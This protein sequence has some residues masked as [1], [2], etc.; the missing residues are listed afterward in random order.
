MVRQRQ[1][2]SLSARISSRSSPASSRESKMKR[3]AFTIAAGPT[4]VGCAQKDGH[5]V[6]H[7]AQRMHFVVSS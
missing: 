5:A 1:M 7:A 3:W 2:P 6:V 4:Y